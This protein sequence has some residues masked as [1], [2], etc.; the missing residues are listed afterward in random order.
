MAGALGARLGGARSY[1]ARVVEDA[2]MG[3][4]GAIAD[5]GMIRQAL[6]VY[7]VACAMN[8]AAIALVAFVTAR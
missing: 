6:R 3:E 8:A 7:R 5:A 4:G 1:A 2:A